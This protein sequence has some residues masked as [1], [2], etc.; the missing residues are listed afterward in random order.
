MDD[1]LFNQ[2]S[3]GEEALQI[4]A[5]MAESGLV[6]L[7]IVDSV[8]ALVPKAELEGDMED[9]I[10]GGQARMMSKAMRKLTAACSNTGCVIIFINQIREKIGVLFGSPETT[11]GGKALKFFASLRME[12]RAGKPIDENKVRMGKETSIKLI[13]NKVGTPFR[14]TSFN[15]MYGI[16]GYPHGV[17]RAGNLITAAVEAGV[18]AKSSSYYSFGDIRVNGLEKFIIAVKDNMD[19]FN[20]ISREFQA[21]VKSEV[22]IPLGDLEDE[23]LAEALEDAE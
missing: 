4:A 21:K 7:I 6:D 14:K 13:K 2:P 10:I 15:L 23:D 19:L 12:I 17:D 3:S 5:D 1:L 11:P 22:V 16:G 20:Q 18:I 8:A 9:N